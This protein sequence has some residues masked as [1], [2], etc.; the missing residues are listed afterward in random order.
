MANSP[1]DDALALMACSGKVIALSRKLLASRTESKRQHY[2]FLGSAR[3][4]VARSR[5][6][7]APPVFTGWPQ[8]GEAG[9]EKRSKT[10]Q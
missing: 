3:D 4:R 2:E 7:L 8:E 9:K 10:R 6:L 1:Y 5:A